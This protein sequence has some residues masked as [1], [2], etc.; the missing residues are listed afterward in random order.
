MKHS[1]ISGYI[2][3]SVCSAF[4]S[5]FSTGKSAAAETEPEYKIRIISR[6]D[7]NANYAIGLL[8]LA[9]TKSGKPYTLSI[10]E[11]A[12]TAMR[13]K[14]SLI[15]GTIDVSWT[16]TNNE[17]E[18]ELLPVRIPLEKGLLG[19]RIFIVHR[20]NKNLLNNVKT[21]DDLRRFSVGQGRGWTDADILKAN[22]FNVV[23]APK[24]ESL[25][26]MV[27]GKRFQI[28]PR[29]VNEPFAEIDKRPNLD[30]AV[31]ENVMVVY[32]MPYYFFVNPARKALMEDIQKGLTLA[33]EDGSFD[34]YFYA[35]QTTKMVIKN[36]ASSKRV[37]FELNN[38]NLPEK[39]PLDNP[40][41]WVKFDE[42]KS[43]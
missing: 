25:F 29:G 28:F 20:D 6:G 36:V 18:K 5:V 21:L 24:Y 33:I 40:K 31:D 1:V 16:A 26:Y 39:T 37:I 22:G 34:A 13:L 30:L 3:A 14:E 9:I 42:L 15:S 41:L 11:G 8:R 19:H 2:F 4:L 27:D 7:A 23:L 35:D 17:L 43:H 10:S 32:K 38:P 12:L